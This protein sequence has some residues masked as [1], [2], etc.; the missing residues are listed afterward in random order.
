MRSL[1]HF[2]CMFHLGGEHIDFSQINSC[3]VF[4]KGKCSHKLTMERCYI[5]AHLMDP[6][7]LNRA[8]SK[9]FRCKLY[10]KIRYYPTGLEMDDLK[11]GKVNGCIECDQAQ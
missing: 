6:D 1:E 10:T 5:I 4:A 7:E 2:Q 8:Q 11:A 3:V 9:C